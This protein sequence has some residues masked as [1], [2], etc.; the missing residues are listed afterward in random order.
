MIDHVPELALRAFYLITVVGN[1]ETLITLGV[2]VTAALL[3]L[4]RR[5]LALGWALAMLGNG[6]LNPTLKHVFERARPIHPTHW[7]T[8]DGFSF[9]SGHS[10]GAV[11]AMGML[12]YLAVRLL[13]RRWHV[14]AWI[15]AAGL[16]FSIGASRVFLRVHFPS[17]VLA[18][19]ASGTAWLT[20]SIASIEL[21][22]WA[23]RRRRAPQVSG[24]ELTR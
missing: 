11:I 22:R 4:R 2:V 19:F 5:G 23:K 20:I 10:S 21:A 7:L 12:A 17:D 6:A 24:V 9:P 14:P 3:V 1:R 8:E 18:G 15:A 16:A 13:P